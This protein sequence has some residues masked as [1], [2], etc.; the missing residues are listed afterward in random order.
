MR[1]LKRNAHVQASL[2][3][4]WYKTPSGAHY[5]SIRA[6][7]P[8][9]LLI[10]TWVAQDSNRSKQ[11]EPLDGGIILFFYR[12]LLNLWTTDKWVR[13]IRLISNLISI[14]TPLGYFEK[15]NAP[16]QASLMVKATQW[17]PL[18]VQ[19]T[20]EQG[21]IEGSKWGQPRY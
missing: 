5:W 1:F 12:M 7:H 2:T 19:K 8:N 3:I 6:D 10:F 16:I 11:S 4:L 21:G 15:R 17:S 13:G 20:M 9:S 18:L 14:L